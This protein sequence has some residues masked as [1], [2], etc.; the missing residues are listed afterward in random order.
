MKSE[1]RRTLPVQDFF[2]QPLALTAPRLTRGEL[3]QREVEHTV[4]ACVIVD[5]L[6]TDGLM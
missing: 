1:S 5:F 6:Q 4:C 2:L 3:L